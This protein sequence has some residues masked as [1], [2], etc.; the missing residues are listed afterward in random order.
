ME[1]EERLEIRIPDAD[2]RCETLAAPAASLPALADVEEEPR[3]L[4]AKAGG[5]KLDEVKPETDF[6]NAPI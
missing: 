6:V 5:V 4:V 1:A 3:T 2:A